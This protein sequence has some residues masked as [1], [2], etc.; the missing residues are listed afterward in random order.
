MTAGTQGSTSGGNPLGCAVGKAVLDRVADPEFLEGVNARAGLL[1]QKLEGLV[2]SH[3]DLF[4]DVRGTGLMLGIRCKEA[5]PCG[6]MVQAGY[7]AQVI[8]V[9][10]ADNVVRLLPALN[11]TEEDINEAITRLEAAAVAMEK[12]PA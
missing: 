6:Q 1:R 4:E 11:V 5:L 9:P 10:A 2:A 7:E 3:P 8:T 12:Q